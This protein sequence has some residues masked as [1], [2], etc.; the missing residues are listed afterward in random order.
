MRVEL[1]SAMATVITSP[2][3]KESFEADEDA[4]A[5]G[6]GLGPEGADHL[7]AMRDDL[8]ELTG[9]F[10][11]KRATMLRWNARRTLALL[12]PDGARLVQRYI[13]GHPATD[14][15][16]T[17]SARFGDFVVSETV[18]RRD[19]SV[20]A[21]VIADMARFERLRS[22]SFW[23]AVASVERPPPPPTA[24]SNRRV[25]LRPGAG[26]DSFEWDL[27]LL[28]HRVGSTREPPTRDR[29][30]LCFVHTGT[31]LGFRVVR[32]TGPEYELVTSVMAGNRTPG[33]R[34]EERPVQHRDDWS[35]AGRP[36]SIA[37]RLVRRGVMEW[38]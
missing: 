10:V 29:C 30:A 23:G 5:T 13:D 11:A 25:T 12:G 7:K 27:R 38:R 34:G 9:S 32:L 20:W 26:A 36:A 35:A 21:D 16:P 33:R 19:S 28:Y 22:A 17:E 4:F 3:A 18:A 24:P 37:D 8:A 15:F 31:S 2:A 1:E 6:L 14:S